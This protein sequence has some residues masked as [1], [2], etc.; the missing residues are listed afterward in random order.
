MDGAC[1]GK[2]HCTFSPAQLVVDGIHPCPVEVN[3][4]LEANYKCVK[5][6]FKLNTEN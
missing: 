4:Y 3:S 1:S 5:G 2:E 6:D